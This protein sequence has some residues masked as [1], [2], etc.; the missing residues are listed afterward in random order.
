MLSGNGHMPEE[1][2]MKKREL[3]SLDTKELEKV[4]GGT[5]NGAQPW[6]VTKPKTQDN[7]QPVSW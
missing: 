2:G 6:V 1:D 4:V 3:E 5:G 7:T